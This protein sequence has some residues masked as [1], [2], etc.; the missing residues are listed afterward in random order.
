MQ[1]Y[2]HQNTTATRS[3]KAHNILKTGQNYQRM[4]FL[5]SKRQSRTLIPLINYLNST[6]MANFK[7]ASVLQLS[8]YNHLLQPNAIK[9]IRI[10]QQL[11]RPLKPSLRNPNVYNNT[12]NHVINKTV[13]F[14]IPLVQVVHYHA[15]PMDYED[16]YDQNDTDSEDE[17]EDEYIDEEEET[18]LEDAFLEGFLNNSLQKFQVAQ[19]KSRSI[20]HTDKNASLVPQGG[21][22]TPLVLFNWLSA[23]ASR[24]CLLQMA[25][26]ESLVW[27][28]VRGMILGSILT[29]NIT[30]EKKVITRYL[31]NDWK[32]WDNIKASYKEPVM[33]GDGSSIC[34]LD[35]FVVDLYISLPKLHK[36]NLPILEQQCSMTVLCQTNSSVSWDCDNGENFMFQTTF[37][38]PCGSRTGDVNSGNIVKTKPPSF[39]DKNQVLLSVKQGCI[40]QEWIKKQEV[41]CS[42]GNNVFLPPTKQYDDCITA[43]LQL[44][45]KQQLHFLVRS[46]MQQ[47]NIY[48][49]VYLDRRNHN[50]SICN[51]SL[52]SY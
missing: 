14:D 33:F 25:S 24:R 7:S 6:P 17:S 11:V 35:R 18:I 42:S 49:Q 30:F 1:L 40:N 2:W 16:E 32:V 9:T 46:T 34:A 36:A 45:T 39:N 21:R 19:V 10:K 48:F 43:Q 29:Q 52:Q 23:G 37:T 12:R 27:A 31:T 8:P 13:Q 51:R 5:S 20:T 47:I 26:L 38:P 50:G 44:D 4:H 15:Y 41:F 28:N 22:K 3:T